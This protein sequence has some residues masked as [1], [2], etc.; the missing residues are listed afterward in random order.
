M[1]PMQNIPPMSIR[2]F[3]TD[4]GAEPVRDWLNTTFPKKKEKSSAGT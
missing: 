3:M 2:F 4:S 1:R